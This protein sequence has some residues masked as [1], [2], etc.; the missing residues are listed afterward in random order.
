LR[1][2]EFVVPLAGAIQ[3]MDVVQQEEK[4][5]AE[6]MQ[7]QIRRLEREKTDLA[8]R[9]N[10]MENS[11]RQM[12]SL[13]QVMEGRMNDCCRPKETIE[14]SPFDPNRPQLLQNRPNPFDRDT[15]IRY[16]LPENTRDAVL[17]ITDDR[18]QLIQQIDIRETGRGTIRIKGDQLGSGGYFYSLFIDGRQVDVK[19]MVLVR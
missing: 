14:S 6:K 1:Y 13:L 16:Y 4:E 2:A 5:K 8:D 3:E 17:R 9:L 15:E 10:R 7:E 12:E 19:K 11:V 18:G